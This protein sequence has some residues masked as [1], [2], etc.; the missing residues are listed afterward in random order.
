MWDTLFRR[1]LYPLHGR[2]LLPFEFMVIHYL[3]LVIHALTS[4]FKN[5]SWIFL[6]EF[7]LSSILTLLEVPLPIPYGFRFWSGCE[8]PFP[9]ISILIQRNKIFFSISFDL[10]TSK[11][12][13]LSSH[14][15]GLWKI[16]LHILGLTF[17]TSLGLCQ[18]PGV[19]IKY[20]CPGSVEKCMALASVVHSAFKKCLIRL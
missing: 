11:F 8:S 7:A 4:P 17:T 10:R 15:F 13:T 2:T 1:G 20:Q 18:G 9:P 19:I 14:L 6:P 5:S 12:P 3:G 16:E